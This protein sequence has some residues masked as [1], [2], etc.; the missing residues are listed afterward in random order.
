M[1]S[2]LS[3]PPESE[4]MPRRRAPPLLQASAK[5][6]D[7]ECETSGDSDYVWISPSPL[8]RPSAE[9]ETFPAAPTFSTPVNSPGLSTLPTALSSCT[10]RG[11]P[12]GLPG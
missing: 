11:N 4:T 8:L 10:V 7:K 2:P 9:V 6:L 3:T 1:P 12:E 5:G